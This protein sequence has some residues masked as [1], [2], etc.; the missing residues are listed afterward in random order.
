[1]SDDIFSIELIRQK[2][3]SKYQINANLMDSSKFVVVTHNQPG[4]NFFAQ[5]A[6]LPSISVGTAIQDTPYSTIKRAG[7]KIMY[8]PLVVTFL[9]D[10][11]LKVWEELHNWIVGYSYP[12]SGEEYKRQLS[13]G[14][15][16]DITLMLLKNSYESNLQFRFH[17]AFPTSLS[18]ITVS[19]MEDGE[20][21]LT[22]DVIFD[23]DTFI[24]QR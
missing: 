22:A 5:G 4:L 10:E 18:P 8:E 7:D 17:N 9:V 14:I 12:H 24:I 19:S 21:A 11:D 13:K 15:Y 23:Y 1:M 20:G 3:L 6:T 2:F 16:A